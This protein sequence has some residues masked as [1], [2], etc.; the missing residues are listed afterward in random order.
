MPLSFRVGDPAA[1][2]GRLQTLGL[3][4]AS[5]AAPLVPSGRALVR[6]R[7]PAVGGDLA[8]DVLVPLCL[9]LG[10]PVGR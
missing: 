1:R 10:E 2:G 3:R 6:L 5:L 4:S 8:I 9:G 7:V